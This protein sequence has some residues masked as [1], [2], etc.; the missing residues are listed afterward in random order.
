[1]PYYRLGRVK[2]I[3]DTYQRMC[4]RVLIHDLACA[5]SF[6]WVREG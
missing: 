4:S 3:E 1:M 5:S 6:A 2:R